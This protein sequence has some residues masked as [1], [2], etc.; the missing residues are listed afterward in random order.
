MKKYMKKLLVLKIMNEKENRKKITE[1]QK[2]EEE[3]KRRWQK[4]KSMI[5]S[6]KM[7]KKLRI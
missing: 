6:D 5:G 1:T 2:E 4:I 3:G 7:K